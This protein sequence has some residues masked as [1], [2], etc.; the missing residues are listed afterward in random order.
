MGK[1]ILSDND[2]CGSFKFKFKNSLL[3]NWP[4][5]YVLVL[6][7]CTALLLLQVTFCCIAWQSSS[8]GDPNRKQF[9]SKQERWKSGILTS[10]KQ[11]NDTASNNNPQ[12]LFTKSGFSSTKCTTIVIVFGQGSDLAV[13]A[14]TLPRDLDDWGGGYPLP[15][16]ASTH[17]AS[18]CLVR[19]FKYDHLTELAQGV[20]T[21]KR[22][23]EKHSDTS[24]RKRRQS[25]QTSY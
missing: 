7:I 24:R 8:S 14:T 15:F 5:N 3:F 23:T 17:S 6:S 18:R 16:P 19:F 11:L 25:I 13:G 2:I 9:Q 1:D 12:V 21:W 4:P 10:F 20:I 22:R